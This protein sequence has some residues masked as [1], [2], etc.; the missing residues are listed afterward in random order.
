MNNYNAV[1]GDYKKRYGLDYATPFA[2]KHENE[3]AVTPAMLKK[4]YGY[5]SGAEN[6][7]KEITV[8]IVEA[9]YTESVMR[10]L[11][12]FCNAFSLPPAQIEIISEKPAFAS[13]AVVSRWKTETAADTQWVHVFAPGAH[14]RCYFARSDD[15]YDLFEMTKL[16]DSEC[17]IVLLCFGKKEF[18]GQTVYNDFFAESK[19]FY[20]CASGNDNSVTFPSSAFGVLS[21]GGTKLYFDS[22]GDVIGKE[23]PWDRSGRGI[24]RYSTMPEYQKS[25]GIYGDKRRVP[26]ISFFACGSGGAAVFC[27]EK[28]WITACG[29]SISAAC[30]AGVCASVAQKDK[31]I[32]QKKASYFYELAKKNKNNAVSGL[33][34]DTRIGLGVPDVRKLTGCV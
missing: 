26:D 29:T 13:D 1:Y 8:G 32:L 14:V 34:Y 2:R 15:F 24:S 31:S 6:C 22:Y 25:A 27:S 11:A 9:F 30:F 20:I 28:G 33:L 23:L 10:D 16:A 21:V 4:H 17:D 3:N 19:A 5:K 18:A 12:V 7:G